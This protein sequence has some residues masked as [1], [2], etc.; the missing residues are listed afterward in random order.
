MLQMMKEIVKKNDLCVLS[1][2]SEGKP[3]CSLM[4]YVC[5]EEGNEIYM[6]T[7][8]QSKKYKNLVKN[9]AVSLLIDTRE[10]EIGRHRNHIK[11]LTVTGKFTEITDP[12]RKESI[13]S[14]ISATRPHLLNFLRD[15]DC[16]VFSIK[17]ESFQLLHG[18]ENPFFARLE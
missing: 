15:P 8:V 2:V 6:V 12:A 7:Q 13:R 4:S 9:A 14:Q 5:N 3:H 10:E 11:A 17:V 18:V 1:T 16:E